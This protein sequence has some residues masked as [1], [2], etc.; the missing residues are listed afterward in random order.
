[1]LSNNCKYVVY[2]VLEDGI[3]MYGFERMATVPPPKLIDDVIRIGRTINDNE[4]NVQNLIDNRQEA[5]QLVA[6]ILGLNG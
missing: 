2:G 4:H 3:N 1:M 5:E 6:A